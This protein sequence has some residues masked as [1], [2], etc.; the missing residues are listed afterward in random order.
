V[1]KKLGALSVGAIAGHYIYTS[2]VEQTS[3]EAGNVRGFIPRSAGFGLDD[4]A[5]GLTIAVAC[6]FALR[7]IGS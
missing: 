3:D 1:L 4:V 5:H 2:F 6:Y 7:V